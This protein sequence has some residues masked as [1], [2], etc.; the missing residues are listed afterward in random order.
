MMTIYN[1]YYSGEV[2]GDT[3]EFLLEEYGEEKGWK[4]VSDIPDEVVFNEMNIQDEFAWNDVENELKAFLDNSSWIVK[5]TI[6]KWDGPKDAGEIICNFSELSPVW[7]DCDY[8]K[9]YDKGGHFYIEASHHDDTN[10]FELKRLTEA[11]TDFVDRHCYD[12]TKRELHERLWKNP[13]YTRLP[14]YAKALL[15]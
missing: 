5:G 15:S 11:G 6:G 14:R 12:M 13:K 7:T 2:Y 8:I 3:V 10:Y 1:N 9:M 4:S